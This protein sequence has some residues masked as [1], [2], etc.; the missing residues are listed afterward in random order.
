MRFSIFRT[1][2]NYI[3]GVG[4]CQL[5]TTGTYRRGSFG[6]ESANAHGTRAHPQ[7][8]VVPF[9]WRPCHPGMQ[10]KGMLYRVVVLGY[11]A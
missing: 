3:C 10:V 7:W 1:Q 6:A 9:G 11:R 4:S 5:R 8:R 2:A